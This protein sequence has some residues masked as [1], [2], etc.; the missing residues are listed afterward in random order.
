M[1]VTSPVT[2]H[3]FGPL[4][5]ER[6]LEL[7]GDIG[8]T[9]REQWQKLVSSRS[10][11]AICRVEGVNSLG[12]EVREAGVIKGLCSSFWLNPRGNSRNHVGRGEKSTPGEWILGIPPHQQASRHE[13]AGP[14]AFRGGQA[15]IGRGM[16]RRGSWQ[17]VICF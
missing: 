2:R 17:D 14:L 11:G 8:E 5:A 7:P 3:P 13:T 6:L 15:E 4:T 1:S 9:Y 10:L 16:K 12:P